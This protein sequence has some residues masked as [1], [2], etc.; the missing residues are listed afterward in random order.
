MDTIAT[1]AFVVRDMRHD[2]LPYVCDI[3][4]QHN[5]IVSSPSPHMVLARKWARGLVVTTTDDAQVV[6][7]FA[8]F[9]RRAPSAYE[10]LF[11][12]TDRRFAHRGVG[13]IALAYM[14]LIF[15]A[16]AM[17]RRLYADV[18]EQFVNGQVWLYNRGWIASRVVTT[19][20][21]TYFRFVFLK[22]WLTL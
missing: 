8:M 5:A 1:D 2:D 12:R 18:P 13:T 15:Q 14:R 7:G 21:Q 20:E 22:D 6:A 10:L 3:A 16:S 19:P 4:A 11:L 9:Q 17:R